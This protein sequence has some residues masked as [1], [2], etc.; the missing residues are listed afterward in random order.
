MAGMEVVRAETGMVLTP[1]PEDGLDPSHLGQDQE[2]ILPVGSCSPRCLCQNREEVTVPWGLT[3]TP[4]AR[5]DLQ[6]NNYNSY[7]DGVLLRKLPTG[8]TR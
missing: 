3:P 8:G 2:L 7:E 6:A 4:N 5:G 1:V